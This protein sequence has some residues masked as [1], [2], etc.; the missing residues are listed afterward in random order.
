M[1][2]IMFSYP[3]LRTIKIHF[4][5]SY[6]KICDICHIG[7]RVFQTPLRSC[8]LL[9]KVSTVSWSTLLVQKLCHQL[10]KKV[11]VTWLQVCTVPPCD[12]ILLENVQEAVAF[13]QQ[14]LVIHCR[15]TIPEDNI[16]L[17][18]FWMALHR[19]CCTS[20]IVVPC[21]INYTRTHLFDTRKQYT[22][23]SCF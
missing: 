21:S 11:I 13:L 19:R 18:L 9:R 4:R 10:S 6:M 1:N 5:D 14:Y 3:L 20:L 12:Q 17:L 2:N 16:P 22:W 8:L 7:G 15:A 23:S